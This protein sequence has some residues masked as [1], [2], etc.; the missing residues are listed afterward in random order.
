MSRSSPS[1]GALFLSP[2]L[3]GKL[4]RVPLRVVRGIPLS[5]I[6]FVLILTITPVPHRS[7]SDFIEMF[8]G[9]GPSRVRDLFEKARQKLPA[10]IFIDEI[11]AIGRKRSSGGFSYVPPFLCVCVAMICYVL[12]LCTH[13]L[14][15]FPLCPPPPLFHNPS[16]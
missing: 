2:C 4:S 15:P 3:R 11:D 7:G 8:V 10:I 9:V 6:F 13:P 14:F 5:F 1:G 16:A 12:I